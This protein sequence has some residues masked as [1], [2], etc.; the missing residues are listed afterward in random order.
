MTQFWILYGSRRVMHLLHATG[1]LVS[2]SHNFVNNLAWTQVIDRVK[3]GYNTVP[4][5]TLKSRPLTSR[6]GVNIQFINMHEYTEWS[7]LTQWIECS[8]QNRI[9]NT[10]S[11]RVLSRSSIT[12][13]PIKNG[14]WRLGR[15]NICQISRFCKTCV[16]AD[17]NVDES[18]LVVTILGLDIGIY[19]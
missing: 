6:E 15:F 3:H 8:P 2:K 14:E 19:R 10:S 12:Y 5:V 16:K 1:W 9:Y 18:N 4:K 11:Y 17:F 7:Y 13:G